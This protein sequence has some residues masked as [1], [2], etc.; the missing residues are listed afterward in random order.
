M[1]KPSRLSERPQILKSS[2]VTLSILSVCLC[3]MIIFR[4]QI[5]NQYKAQ[6]SMIGDVNPEYLVLAD[7][8]LNSTFKFS[9]QPSV[10]ITTNNSPKT[11]ADSIIKHLLNFT[12]N[13]AF[14][15]I[16]LVYDSTLVGIQ[17]QNTQTLGAGSRFASACFIN[18]YNAQK[19]SNLSEHDFTVLLLH[20][21]GH[22][23]GL[24]H[25]KNLVCCMSSFKGM[26]ELLRGSETNY[27]NICST[28][29]DKWLK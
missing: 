29:I 9:L 11:N 3:F 7:S 5:S 24:K 23:L 8:I 10:S 1:F 12:P 6:L 25:C 22:S 21:V 28:K 27:C 16:G 4:F 2:L 14:L 13:K 15:T 26:D 18:T 20:E 19:K 17:D